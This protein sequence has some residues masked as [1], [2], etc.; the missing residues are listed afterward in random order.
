[1]CQTNPTLRFRKG[2][3]NR[4]K[5]CLQVLLGMGHRKQKRKYWLASLLNHHAGRGLR[6]IIKFP[7]GL[8]KYQATQW[9]TM[10]SEPASERERDEADRTF[11][12]IKLELVAEETT[13]LALKLVREN[14]DH[15][16]DSD[17]CSDPIMQKSPERDY[18]Q[19]PSFRSRACVSSCR[20]RGGQDA[21]DT[22]RERK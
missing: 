15:R 7:G 1:M 16:S 17:C 5:K 19:S 9:C 20:R 3:K 6:R 12:Q 22:D 11:L 14:V 4:K 8:T 13:Y 2:N 18:P 21:Q 10:E